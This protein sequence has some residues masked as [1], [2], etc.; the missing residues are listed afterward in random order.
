M[1]ETLLCS[2][3]TFIEASIIQSIPA[4]TQRR[5]ELGIMESAREANIAPAKK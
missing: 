3:E 2:I 5:G 4:A 1:H